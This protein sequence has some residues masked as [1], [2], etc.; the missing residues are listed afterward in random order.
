MEKQL[1]CFIVVLVH[2]FPFQE[3]SDGFVKVRKRDLEKLT[4]EV[5]QLREFLPKV[6]NGDLIDM[7]HK[8]RAADTSKLPGDGE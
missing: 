6:V 4:T 3:N 1:H 8:A 7:L 2:A 5:M